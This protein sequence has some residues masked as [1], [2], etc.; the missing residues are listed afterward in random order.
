MTLEILPTHSKIESL[1]R[2]TRKLQ[3]SSSAEETLRALQ[4]G[5]AEVGGFVASI[6]IS[7]RG[8]PPGHHC[9]V[10]LQLTDEPQHELFEG[11]HM[12]SHP[13]TC[14]GV[15]GPI[16]AQREPQ[17]V[18]DV[19]WSRDPVFHETLDG[20]SSVI[21]L[22]LAGDL[23]PMDW[24]ILVKKSPQRFSVPEFEEAVERA[25][26]VTPLLENQIRAGE[27]ALAHHQADREARQ[28]GE[29][30]RA[31]LPALPPRWRL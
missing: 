6:L 7:T 24:A 29:L 9:L 30:Q 11:K 14:D 23:L 27:S 18:Q 22:P 17:L 25:A 12:Q 26:L 13:S 31:L 3:Q 1:R 28:V 21:A 10:R 20:Y 4:R 8:L 15:L 16:L 19:D 5:F 2:L